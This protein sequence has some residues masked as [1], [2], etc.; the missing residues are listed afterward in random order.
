LSQYQSFR[1]TLEEENSLIGDQVTSQILSGVDTT[2]DSS[3]SK[4][5]SLEQLEKVGRD[6]GFSVNG[7]SHHGDRLGGVD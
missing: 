3:S 4:V 7:S 1:R 6:I 5:G 2:N